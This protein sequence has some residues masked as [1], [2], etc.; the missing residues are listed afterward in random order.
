MDGHAWLTWFL[1]GIGLFLSELAAPGFILLFFGLGAWLA[2]LACLAANPSAA[3]QIAIFLAAS[4]VSLALL[5]RFFTKIFSGRARPGAEPG[6]MAQAGG[7]TALVTA[8]IAPGAPGEIQ[9]RGS[10]WR[11][12]ADEPIAAGAPVVIEGPLPGDNLTFKVK[13]VAT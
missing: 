1:I 2:A 10:Y 5:R 3:V 4:L 6:D 12:A 9:F 11:A 7:Q 13:P 8:A